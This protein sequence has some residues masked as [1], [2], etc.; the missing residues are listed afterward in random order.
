MIIL[1]DAF[2]YKK[3]RK[4]SYFR[5]IIFALIAGFAIVAFWRGV[6]GLMDVL[7]FPN[8]H[9]LS[10]LASALLGIIILVLTGYLHKGLL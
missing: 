5:Q 10:V 6:W 9:F 2:M 7:F 3:F 1:A 8:D 4:M